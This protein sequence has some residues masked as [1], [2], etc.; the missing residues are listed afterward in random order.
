MDRDSYRSKPDAWQ[1]GP[2]DPEQDRA[3]DGDASPDARA[4]ADVFNAHAILSALSHDDADEATADDVPDGADDAAEPD[5]EAALRA[6]FASFGQET[7][8]DDDGPPEEAHR[9]ADEASADDADGA[10]EPDLKAAL[11]ATFAPAAEETFEDDGPQDAAHDDDAFDASPAAERDAEDVE[12]EDPA[13]DLP[14]EPLPAHVADAI[15]SAPTL[16]GENDEAPED[17]VPLF[18]DEAG[19][20][21]DQPEAPDPFAAEQV[22][23]PAEMSGDD[24][25]PAA[26][27]LDVADAET[28]DVT[29]IG[30]PAPDEPTPDEPAAQLFA[31]DRTDA[32][33][34]PDATET[35]PD[36]SGADTSVAAVF[37]APE[38]SENTADGDGESGAVFAAPSA[39][40]AGPD[41]ET[42]FASIDDPDMPGRKP[43]IAL[44]GEFSAGKSTLS[45]LLIGSDPLPTRVTATQLPPVW[46]S[47]GDGQA[48]REDLDG[49]THAIDIER[50]GDIDPAETRVVRLFC[51]S[52][53]LE[54]C[55]II[56]MPGISDPNMSSDVWERLIDKADGVIWCTHATQAWR[57]SEAAVW[58]S[59]DH[60]IF[61]N[62][63]L[64]ITRF[65]KLRNE[66]DRA[67]VLKRVERE[68]RG[69]FS[70][71][72][73][74]SLTQ[75]LSAGDDAETWQQSGAADFTDRL[76]SILNALATSLGSQTGDR[77]GAPL[78][79][80]ATD[81]NARPRSVRVHR[82]RSAAPV[83]PRR[84]VPRRVRP[85]AE[86][87]RRDAAF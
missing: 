62:S 72:L 33:S 1:T 22:S 81:A 61:S 63:L 39:A 31:D 47:W 73:P 55:D 71:R 36:A 2:S 37:P 51:R 41:D 58:E 77:L 21:E 68:T 32:A 52:D 38:E 80:E 70:A 54:L 82:G 75:A 86:S 85:M 49:S 13:S 46:I 8:E 66:I 16:E 40:D 35:L 84:V 4:P 56:D 64:L 60:A 57:Q 20:V 78:D 42:V 48:Y 19:A 26:S 79:D 23:T 18:D 12:A 7:Y 43:R 44:M 27:G 10:M 28:D 83:M 6:T 30:D 24:A 5:L 29:A 59:L 25:D 45:N 76:V 9:E 34:E 11:R 74:I 17:D 50:I 69:L 14:G 67:R 53:I 3:E 15:A 87:G 65:D